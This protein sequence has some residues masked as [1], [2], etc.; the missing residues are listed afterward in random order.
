[1]YVSVIKSVHDDLGRLLMS[2]GMATK[3]SQAVSFVQD[4]L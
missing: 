4:E 3:V 2:C 1:M